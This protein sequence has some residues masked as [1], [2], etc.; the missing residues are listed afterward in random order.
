MCEFAPNCV[1]CQ[2]ALTTTQSTQTSFG[3]ASAGVATY[4]TNSIWPS[5]LMM[6][7]LHSAMM[8]QTLY[9][10][11]NA[12]PPCKIGVSKPG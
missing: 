10:L 6:S 4:L 5:S 11:N 9:F 2:R 12:S 8:N 1:R 7:L 3:Q